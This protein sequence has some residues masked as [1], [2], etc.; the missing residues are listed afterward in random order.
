M[1]DQSLKQF[2]PFKE[3]RPVQEQAI[4]FALDCFLNK[5]LK[6]V[7]LELP[8]G[9][10][11]SAVGITVARALLDNLSGD[12]GGSYFLTT[13][14]VL[15]DQYMRDFGPGAM[16]LMRTIKSSTNYMCAH[17]QH[18][19]C[20]ESKRVLP[21]VRGLDEAKT[22]I[23]T[24]TENCPYS[25][26]KA[27]FISAALGVTNFSYFLAET[28][29]AG[30]L[31]PRKVLVVDECHSTEGELSKFVEVSFSEKFAK[32]AL[33]CAP[34][35]SRDQV[36]VI[37]WVKRSYLPKLNRK[38][39]TLESSI[40]KATSSGD[41]IQEESKQ[42]ETLDKHVCKVHR[43]VAEYNPKNW[44]LNVVDVKLKTGK[45]LH[46]KYEFKP[47]DVSKSAND[48]LFRFGD[49]V[50]LMSATIL[51]KNAFCAS[52]GLDPAKVGFMSV[53]SP[54]PVENRKVHYLPVGSMSKSS[55]D[56][57]LPAM[58]EVVR[59]LIDKHTGEKGVIH[60]SNFKIANYIFEHV[61]SPRLLIHDST[62]REEVLSKHIKSS[63]PTILV[64]PSMTEGVDLAD[65]NSRFQILCKVPYP[66]L[67]DAVVKRRM[68]NDMNWYPYQTAKTIIQSLGRSIRNETDFAVSYVLDADW[69]NFYS[70]NR[71]FFP[72]DFDDILVKNV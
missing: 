34:P 29:Y 69:E 52:L 10:G 50:L 44:I 57:T 54:F 12:K 30:K 38:I 2:F 35:K 65:D 43:F 27:D 26:S 20:A 22:F 5:G 47:I 25:K 33:S 41:D 48:L 21:H 7:V 66:Y 28:M 61:K 67:G 71:K 46:Y 9:V 11:K 63:D 49:Y 32:E 72:A 59:M 18:Q 19:S 36:S 60:A 23:K 42:Y 8:V 31:E 24:C 17:H 70:R 37:D 4:K 68:E 56:S 64:S 51:D 55:I 62:N 39:K 58:A 3:A 45:L 15:Q 14:K 53:P 6:T 16:D 13:Q 40:K 1:E